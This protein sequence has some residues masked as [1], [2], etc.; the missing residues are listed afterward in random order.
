MRRLC[1]HSPL[2][3]SPA[4]L[5]I[6]GAALW[7]GAVRAEPPWKSFLGEKP[8]ELVFEAEWWINTEPL[9]L[10]ELRGKVVWL[11]YHF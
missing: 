2:S 4:T 9:T 5:L 6:C 10:E 1:S 8:P 11:Q 3:K 7:C